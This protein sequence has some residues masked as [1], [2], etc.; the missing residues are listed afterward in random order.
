VEAQINILGRTNQHHYF[1]CFFT[2]ANFLIEANLKHASVRNV[3]R[4][5]CQS[6]FSSNIF[7]GQ[8]F[9]IVKGDEYEENDKKYCISQRCS[10]YDGGRKPCACS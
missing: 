9:A 8:I 5:A 10:S 1:H 3:C 4:V 6:S 7:A 2:L